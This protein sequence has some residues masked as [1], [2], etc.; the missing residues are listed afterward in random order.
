[1][2]KIYFLVLIFWLKPEAVGLHIRKKCCTTTTTTKVI[3]SFLTILLEFSKLYKFFIIDNAQSV[4]QLESTASTA[5]T[6]NS[7]K[8]YDNKQLNV[9]PPVLP[10]TVQRV[11]VPRPFA[12]RYDRGRGYHSHR[13][14]PNRR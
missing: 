2:N 14:R 13:G 1:M 9:P 12:P 11:V 5:T 4:Q 10:P 3:I 7:I 8:S 6:V